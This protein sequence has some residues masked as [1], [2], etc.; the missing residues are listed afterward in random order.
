MVKE[1]NTSIVMDTIL[2]YHSISRA[3]IS[4]LTGLN[5]GTVSSLVLELMN[6]HLVFETGTGASSGGRKPVMLEFNGDTGYVVGVDLGVNYILTILTNMQ[7]II[8]SEHHE[9]TIGLHSSE[10]IPLLVRTIGIVSSQVPPSPYGITGIGIGVPGMVDSHG[11]VLFAPNLGW[12]HVDLR[13]AVQLYYPQIP[14]FVDNEANMGAIGEK[15]YGT[16]KEVK[17]LIYISV[18]MGIGA[19]IILNN[20]VFRGTAGYSGETGHMTIDANGKQCRCGN[21]GCWELYAS[22]QALSTMG[23]TIQPDSKID[24]LESF[25]TAAEAGQVPIIEAFEKIGHYLGIGI[26]NIM[27]IFNPDLIIIG[28]RLTLAEQWVSR[29]LRETVEQRALPIQRQSATVQ[30]SDLSSHSTALG[31]SF[32]AVSAFL[33]KSTSRYN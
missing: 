13:A 25:I 5:K 17:N 20:E 6:Q 24:S 2:R 26:A 12:T 31:A 14:I 16:G 4:E 33:Q 30:F 7:G 10:I 29:S 32:M 15:Q 8:I 22:E 23:K 27:N 11:T 18:G 19:G 1:I 28:N 9:D 3:R 21:L